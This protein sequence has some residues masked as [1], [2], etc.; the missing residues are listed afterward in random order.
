LCVLI[1]PTL[2]EGLDFKLNPAI[3]VLE[4]PYGYGVQEQ[5]YARVLR[6]FRPD[7]PVIR[8]LLNNDG[9]LEKTIIQFS[10]DNSPAT[11]R[12][13]ETRFGKNR[14]LANI[15]LTSPV[16]LRGKMPNFVDLTVKTREIAL[17]KTHFRPVLSGLENGG[18]VPS[19][20]PVIMTADTEWKTVVN[21]YWPVWSSFLEIISFS[22]VMYGLS[23]AVSETKSNK[24][25]F[26]QYKE[27]FKHSIYETP[28]QLAR[29]VNINQEYQMRDLATKLE[30]QSDDTVAPA[31]LVPVRFDLPMDQKI[32]L[33]NAPA[34][35]PEVPE[36]TR[37]C[38]LF[39]AQFPNDPLA[40]N[41]REMDV[42]G[43]VP[44]AS[45]AGV[46]NR[47]RARVFASPTPPDED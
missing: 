8:P 19:D 39:N 20:D 28:D 9:R 2:T 30:S 36:S 40:C 35:T 44:S 7:D 5:I 6:T 11:V 12:L 24:D 10:N 32:L 26:T 22:T 37:S 41:R 1:H 31:P 43:P 18:Y 23:A 46:G 25:R 16:G 3:L 38:H 14:G 17:D 47:S 27:L 45:A 21:G 13:G 4:Q 34:E 29:A 15:S 33:R 42:N